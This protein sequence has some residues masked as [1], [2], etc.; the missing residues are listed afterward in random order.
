MRA[1]LPA[2]VI[3]VLASL[4]ASQDLG[5]KAPPQTRAVVIEHVQLHVG[6]GRVLDDASLWFADGRIRGMDGAAPADAERID[7]TGLQ[8]WPGFIDAACQVGLNEIGSISATQDYAEIGEITPEVIA[9]VAVNPDATNIPVTRSN[10]VLVVGVFPAGGAIA[11]HAS[12]VQLEGWTSEDMTVT[13]RAGLVVEWPSLPSRGAGTSK[14]DHDE[15]MQR[16]GEQRERIKATFDSARAWALAHASDPSVA[17]DVRF[18]AMTDALAGTIPVFLKA[19][20]GEAIRSGVA[21]ALS[22]GLRPVVVGAAGIDLCTPLLRQHSIPVVITGVHRLP[23][24]RDESYD[25]PFTLPARLAEA[26]IT[27]CIAGE[28]SYANERN[29]P[30]HVA[31]AVAFGLDRARAE[32]AVTLD[33]AT[34]LGVADRLGSLEVGKRATLFL[35]AGDPLDVVSSIRAAWIDGRRIDLANKQTRLGDKYR[36]KYRQLGLWPEDGADPAARR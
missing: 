32:R 36:T 15:V 16:V 33:A 22:S 27:F 28:G 23:G 20:G 3:V 34:V 19:H 8:L 31:T 11:G 6:D 9:A 12:V 35:A 10:G 18:A 7:G 13:A 25:S 5:V 1:L 14:S 30:Y 29:L 26:G 2:L 4:A 21:W 24:R 17:V